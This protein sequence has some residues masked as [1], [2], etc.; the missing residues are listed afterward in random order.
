MVVRAA[1]VPSRGTVHV[2]ES[3]ESF[4]PTIGDLTFS[5]LSPADSNAAVNNDEKK[6]GASSEVR[7]V[8][9]NSDE[10]KD[11]GGDSFE[12]FL[13]VAS[14]CNVAKVWLKDGE[15]WTARGDPTECAIQ[16]FAHRFKHSRE[17]L[18]EGDSPKWSAFPF[19]FS[20][21]LHFPLPLC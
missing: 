14:M 6:G 9:T 16:T 7:P 1:W 13:N 19:P 12:T 17:S 3:S 20:L 21:F 15:G 4:N 11:K 10:L 5:K 2:G 18:T 8:S